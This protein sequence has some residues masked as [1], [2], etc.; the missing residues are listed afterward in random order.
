MLENIHGSLTLFDLNCTAFAENTAQKA[1][2]KD[3]CSKKNTKRYFYEHD[4]PFITVA[5]NGR[6]GIN[7]NT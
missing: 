5:L 7:L 3:N 6:G 1:K 4:F 2:K